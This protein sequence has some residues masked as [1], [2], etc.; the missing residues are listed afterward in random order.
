MLKFC[1]FQQLSLRAFK[2]KKVLVF[3]VMED[4]EWSIFSQKLKS[5]HRASII[6]FILVSF[7]WWLL[8]FSWQAQYLV[9][10]PLQFFVAGTLVFHGI[11]APECQVRGSDSL[12]AIL[13]DRFLARFWLSCS[14][15][16]IHWLCW[17]HR[18]DSVVSFML[19]HS[20]ELR[21]FDCFGAHSLKWVGSKRL[22]FLQKKKM[23]GGVFLQTDLFYWARRFFRDSERLFCFTCFAVFD[24]LPLCFPEGSVL[25]RIQIWF[26]VDSSVIQSDLWANLET[27]LFVTLET[28]K[29]R[30]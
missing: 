19:Y 7:L 28:E 24:V 17:S 18:L 29:D 30:A 15:S 21:W 20:S 11:F 3:G 9:I 2:S 10:L 8:Q 12:F 22:C 23:F 5:I 26:L 6:Q 16:K 13:L 1:L 14:T 25:L 4:Q 27:T